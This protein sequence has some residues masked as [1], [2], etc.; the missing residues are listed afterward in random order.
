MAGFFLD[1]LQPFTLCW[2]KLL[3]K[4]ET[5]ENIMKMNDLLVFMT[6]EK[7][8]KTHGNVAVRTDAN[9]KKLDA[10]YRLNWENFQLLCFILNIQ[11]QLP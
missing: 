2:K 11:V 8:K 3:K 6:L 10:I 9:M 7:Y 4:T 1:Y 5:K